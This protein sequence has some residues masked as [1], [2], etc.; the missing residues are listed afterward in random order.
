MSE[1]AV[2][3]VIEEGS[4]V[5]SEVTTEEAPTMDELL[6]QATSE[7]D[8]GMEPDTRE[9]EQDP[10]ASSDT[11]IDELYSHMQS[12]QSTK[13]NNEIDDAV[14]SLKGFNDGLKQYPDKMLKGY[15]HQLANEDTRFVK[16]F[17]FRHQNPQTWNKILSGV[18]KGLTGSTQQESTI[19]SDLESVRSAINTNQTTTEGPTD[20]EV[21]TMSEPDF[22]KH[23]ESLGIT[24]GSEW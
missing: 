13:T 6:A 16:A 9:V 5:E 7:F 17:Q 1:E 24:T 18:A 2:T 12:E 23:Q 11:R 3:D 4:Q 19:T 15:L 14:Q 22:M 8:K 10:L 21:L 20:A